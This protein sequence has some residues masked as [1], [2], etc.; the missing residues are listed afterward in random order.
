MKHYILDFCR[1]GLSASA[2]GPVVLAII[3]GILGSTGQ[4]TALSPGD[5]CIGV[6]S[7]TLM[8]FIAAGITV[9]YQIEQLPLASAIALHGGVLYLDYLIMYLLNNWI[10]RSAGGIGRFTAFF[11]AG[12]ALVWVFIYLVTK[13]KTDRINQTLQNQTQ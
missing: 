10:P 6:L 2:G 1:R 5:V 13:R 4:V 12:Y 3:Y 7:V 9:V 8:A 11:V